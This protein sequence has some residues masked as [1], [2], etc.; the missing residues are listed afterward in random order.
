MKKQ[1]I[2]EVDQLQKIAGLLKEGKVVH[3]SDID[4]KDGGNRDDIFTLEV[5]EEDIQNFEEGN[6]ETVFENDEYGG[7]FGVYK[8][9]TGEYMYAFPDAEFYAKAPKGIR[10]VE[11]NLN[12]VK[13]LQKIAGL[14]KESVTLHVIYE[15]EKIIRKLKDSH[16]ISDKTAKKILDYAAKHGEDLYYDISS[17]PNLMFKAAVEAINNQIKGGALK[18]LQDTN[19]P[20]NKEKFQKN[21][22][23]HIVHADYFDYDLDELQEVAD[24]NGFDV[25]DGGIVGYDGFE[26]VD[27]GSDYQWA[28]ERGDDFPH[29]VIIK[30]REMLKN[31]TIVSFLKRLKSRQDFSA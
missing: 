25:Y 5:S 28:I 26:A 18:E 15:F 31:P 2:N 11:N 13:Q 24:E 16:K 4:F 19:L 27:T 21:I 30:N 12:E 10:I 7:T 3:I 20:H 29:A 17:D 14:L 9:P 8:L 6:V 1:L 22:P 23:I